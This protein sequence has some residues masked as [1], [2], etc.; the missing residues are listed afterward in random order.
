M[1]LRFS[2]KSRLDG[3]EQFSFPFIREL[4]LFSPGLSQTFS[5]YYLGNAVKFQLLIRLR[6]K[7]L[8]KVKDQRGQP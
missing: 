3:L 7:K 8:Q 2:L 1:F 6:A 4:R 5:F